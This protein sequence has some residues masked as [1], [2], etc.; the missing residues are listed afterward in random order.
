VPAEGSIGGN[1]LYT[2]SLHVEALS[3]DEIENNDGSGQPQDLGDISGAMLPEFWGSLGPGG[4]DGD[5]E[6]W[7]S[8][9]VGL[10]ADYRVD[11]HFF[12]EEADLELQ[13]FDAGGE[14]LIGASHSVNDDESIDATLS[15]GTYLLRCYRFEG[16]AANYWLSI[17]FQ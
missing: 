15:P 12:H 13:L 17:L 5:N 7:Y 8:F 10:A 11:A 2:L 3:Y 4:Y 16:G 14:T 6:D 1:A 9:T